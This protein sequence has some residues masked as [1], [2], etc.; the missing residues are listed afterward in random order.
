MVFM[1]QNCVAQIFALLVTSVIFQ[2]LIIIASP[3]NDV[4]DQRLTLLIEASV[5]IYLYALLSLTDF[6]G[7]NTLREEIGQVLALLTWTIVAINVT[8]FFSRC[9][10]RASMFFKPR[11]Q[12]WFFKEKARIEQ[13]KHNALE[14]KSAP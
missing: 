12:A 10:R 2:V 5:S 7:E 4:K 1:R 11:V 3:I 14:E 8:V 6:M 9:I 13:C